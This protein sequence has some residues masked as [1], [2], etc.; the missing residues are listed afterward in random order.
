MFKT[1][2]LQAR[3]TS[4]STLLQEM[5]IC[6]VKTGPF[7]RPSF[8]RKQTK[9]EGGLSKSSVSYRDLC[10]VGKSESDLAFAKS[11]SLGRRELEMHFL[12][13]ESERGQTW[14]LQKA[15]V[16]KPRATATTAGQQGGKADSL[17]FKASKGLSPSPWKSRKFSPGS[18]KNR[19]P[20][21]STTQRRIALAL[22]N[23][24]DEQ[25]TTKESRQ[26]AHS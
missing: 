2:K 17:L 11:S 8:K 6:S 16:V 18:S 4:N 20:K 26:D 1:A 13:F 14:P 12:Q 3:Q 15:V 7:F 24:Q 19:D 22:A 10:V 21:L 9:K 5:Y 23:F 25:R